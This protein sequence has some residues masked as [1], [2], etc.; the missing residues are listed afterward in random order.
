MS[1]CGSPD[2]AVGE[3]G[4][5]GTAAGEVAVPSLSVSGIAAVD[6]ASP[7]PV[8]TDAAGAQVRRRDGPRLRPLSR[9]PHADV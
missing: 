3:I 4:W 7:G 9:P 6:V 8:A 2:V 1:A 5:R